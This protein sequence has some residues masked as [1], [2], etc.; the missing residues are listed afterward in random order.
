MTDFNQLA[1]EIY[2]LCNFLFKDNG[3]S[4]S[5]KVEDLVKEI[6][7]VDPDKWEMK[8]KDVKHAFKRYIKEVN[9]AGYEAV[10]KKFD[11]TFYKS[12]DLIPPFGVLFVASGAVSHEEFI[13]TVLDAPD[14]AQII[15]NFIPEEKFVQTLWD[16]YRH[17]K[18]FME[19]GV[20]TS[21]DGFSVPKL[22]S[23][24][25]EKKTTLDHLLTTFE[26]PK[27]TEIESFIKEAGKVQTALARDL[28]GIKQKSNSS[29][30]QI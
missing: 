28:E 26:A 24:T 16:M 23:L 2:P 19:V 20:S 13:K 22:P 4:G 30:T 3:P 8:G 14:D 5:S 17:W 18:E 9:P 27:W 29:K 10:E 21:V 7:L 1:Q 25:P 15:P 11:K 12:L 6:E